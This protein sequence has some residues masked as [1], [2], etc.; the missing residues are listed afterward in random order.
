MN[1]TKD[2]KDEKQCKGCG[3]FR[4]RS[5]FVSTLGD[6]NPKGKY[7]SECHQRRKEEARAEVAKRLAAR[8]EAYKK[9]M[10]EGRFEMLMRE[11]RYLE[12]CKR[13]YGNDYLD[14]VI[15]SNICTTLLYERDSCPYCGCRIHRQE[16][17]DFYIQYKANLDHMD[18]LILGGEDTLRNTIYVCAACNQKKGDK[19]FLKWLSLLT[20]DFREIARNIY[21]EKHGFAPEDFVE[22]PP[23]NRVSNTGTW[24]V[25][26]GEI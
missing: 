21:I 6:H 1:V 11:A 23:T 16:T 8:N 13:E 7:C 19:P 25:Y 24:Y 12:W 20:T 15:P 3:Q 10:E 18:P 26:P 14:Y 2:R 4:K 22:G 17:D 5:N 9:R